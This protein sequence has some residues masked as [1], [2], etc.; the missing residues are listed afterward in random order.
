MFPIHEDEQYTTDIKIEAGKYVGRYQI[1]FT[2]RGQ[3]IVCT[4]A[5]RVGEEITLWD[6]FSLSR[7]EE[8]HIPDG[9]NTGLFEEIRRVLEAHFLPN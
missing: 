1:Q 7:I 8:K 6:S 4:L 3:S 9:S 2:R 5:M